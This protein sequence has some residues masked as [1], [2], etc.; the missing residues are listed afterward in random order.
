MRVGY[1]RVSTD[2]QSLDAQREQLQAA[3][4]ERIY[5]DKA[6]GKDTD[7]PEL[8][9]VLAFLRVGDVLVVPKLDRLARNTLDML[10]I[11]GDL[12][13]RDIGVQSLAERDID[14]STPAGK[15]MLT[16][17]AAIATFERERMKERQRDGIRLAKQRGVYTGGKVRHDPATIRQ[18]HA[19]GMRPCD[20]AREMQCSEATVH[21]ALGKRV[22]SVQ[23]TREQR[24]PLVV[25]LNGKDQ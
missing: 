2:D 4:C 24:D 3:G 20:I 11:I 9:A 13:K 23:I 7:R 1:C 6:S 21:R 5:E 10:T 22:L 14:T 8:Q 18:K 25:R 19:A 16:V 15:L 17:F 12:G